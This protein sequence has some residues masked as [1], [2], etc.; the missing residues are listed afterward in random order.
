MARTPSSR[1]LAIA[2]VPVGLVLTTVVLFLLI[3]DLG[4]E[5]PPSGPAPELAPAKAGAKVTVLPDVLLALVVI[6]VAARVIGAAFAWLG[7]PPVIGEVLAGILLGPSFLGAI[8][9]VASG[10]LLSPD[11]TGHLNILAQLGV[12]LY[13]FVVGLELDTTGLTRQGLDPVVISSVGMAVPFLLGSALALGLHHRLAPS[14][15]PFTVFAL[16][17]GVAM[18]VTAFPVLA[19][20]LTDRG[21]TGTHLG[22]QA[23]TCAA[24]GDVAAWCL[25][26]LAVGVAQARLDAALR[27]LIGTIAFFAFMVIVVRPLL[28]R[29]LR[30]K[31]EVLT[32]GV[33]AVLLVG[34]LASAW[35]TELIGIHAL[36]GA[37][38]FGALVPHDAPAAGQMEHRLRDAVTVLLLP[39][40]FAFTGL[41]TRIGLLDGTEHWLLCGLIVLIATLGKFGGTL[42][43]AR[44]MGTD[45]RDSAALGVLM[46]TRGLMELVVLNIGLDL[47]VI[48]PALFAMMVVMALVT[49]MATGPILSALGVPSGMLVA[50]PR[51]AVRAQACP[52]GT[53]G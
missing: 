5:T 19:R 37:F 50:P 10:Q 13:L 45:W 8:A 34:V 36:F 17:M 15:V 46:N 52:S 31:G 44:F 23:L 1:L 35:V 47:G 51:R 26:A 22:G 27:T 21:M 25:L 9:P 53:P 29:W 14:G 20:I 49:T 30:A 7:Q 39:A 33:A 28:L 32:Q 16:F 38:L 42:L 24:I 12:I 18:S 6:V 2:L 48:S 11:V 43:A 4:H 3:R 41:R 40:Y